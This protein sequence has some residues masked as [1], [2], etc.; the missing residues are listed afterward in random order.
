MSVRAYAT[1]E[2]LSSATASFIAEVSAKAIAERGR[3]TVAFAGGSLP[4]LV[5]SGLIGDPKVASSIAWDKWEVFF[6]D[7]RCVPLEDND[8]NYKLCKE[9]IFDKV[10]D[11]KDSKIYKYDPSLEP[12][13]AAKDY[14]A[15]LK[16]VFKEESG[17]PSFDLLLLG[18]GPDGHMCSLFPGHPLLNEKSKWISAIVD[19]PKPPPQRITFTLPVVNAARNIAFVAA[20]QGKAEMLK[21][22]I[23]SEVSL[24]A[25]M[26]KPL[27]GERKDVIWFVDTPAAS[28]LSK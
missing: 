16:S 19:S 14:E 26:S 8:S 7:E 27:N 2:E 24:P 12:E 28:M 22:L 25:Q 23:E 4:K 1:K 10:N 9:E 11:I 15:K 17:F 18:F 21:T 3:F 6:C 5:G 20:G 13:Q